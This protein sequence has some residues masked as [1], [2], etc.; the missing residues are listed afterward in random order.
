M[1]YLDIAVTY[2]IC[3]ESWMRFKNA[4][5]SILNIKNYF[6]AARLHFFMARFHFFM[7][8]IF[9]HLIKYRRINHALRREMKAT[10]FTRFVSK[11]LITI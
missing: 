3:I 11:R 10:N 5:E 8:T 9:L 6:S 1:R 2:R 4:C 7:I